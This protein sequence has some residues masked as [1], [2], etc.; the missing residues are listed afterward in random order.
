MEK[1]EGQSGGRVAKKAADVSKKRALFLFKIDLADPEE[2]FDAAEPLT[3]HEFAFLGA[4]MAKHSR[5]LQSIANHSKQF[6]CKA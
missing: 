1:A 5:T 3:C 4:A 2:A 6:H